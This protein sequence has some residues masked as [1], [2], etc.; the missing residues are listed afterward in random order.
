[1]TNADFRKMMMTPRT[2]GPATLGPLGSGSSTPSLTPKDDKGKKML[3]LYFF[4]WN[5]EF[6]KENR[7]RILVIRDM[8]VESW[9]RQH[10]GQS[11][12]WFCSKFF[13][14][15]HRHIFFYLHGYG[16]AK[17]T[18]SGTVPI[19]LTKRNKKLSKCS[20]INEISYNFQP[21]YLEF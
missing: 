12:Q 2:S 4:L 7:K 14:F 20:P 11:I 3:Y 5:L 9:N 6:R 15:W 19:L 1:M 21:P 13:M 18:H 10:H 8:V 16:E 17:N